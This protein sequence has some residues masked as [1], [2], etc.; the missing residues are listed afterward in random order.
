MRLRLRRNPRSARQQGGFSLIEVL[1]ALLV[2]A[3]GLLGLAFMQVLNV[4][5]TGSAEHRTMATNLAGEVLDMMRSNPR[6]V[7]VYQRLTEDSF[8]GVTE[9]AGGCSTVAEDAASAL[10]NIDRW[11]CDVV[12]QLPGG[13]GQVEIDGTQATGY[14]VTVTVSWTDDVG[15]D[16]DE[17]QNAAG[18]GQRTS[19]QVTSLL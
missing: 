5:Y 17:A 16:D 3:L 12:S 15:A 11:R 18:T 9:P 10:E 7:V 6:H 2:L 8:A 13:T 1:I 19:F 4:R 14:T